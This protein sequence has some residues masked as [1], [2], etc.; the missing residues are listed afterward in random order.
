ME[1]V[2]IYGIGNP[3]VDVSVSVSDADIEALGLSKG[4][5][6]LIETEQR[7]R[8]LEHIRGKDVSYGCGGSAPNSMIT[9]AALG[10]ATALGG[11]IADDELGDIYKQRLEQ[12]GV[13]N[14]L[15]VYP[16]E[17]GT[18]IILVTPDGERTMC[19]FL[20]TCM[21][22]RDTDVDEEA[23]RAA[24]WLHF[25]G[26]MFD[27]EGQ[28]A[29]I[30]HAAQTTHSAGGKISFDVADPFAVDR[31]YDAF[32]ELIPRQVDLLFANQLEAEKLTGKSDPLEAAQHFAEHVETAVVKDGKNGSVVVSGGHVTRIKPYPAEL[33][34]SNGAGDT[35]AAAFLSVL[36]EDGSHAQA[37]QFA[38]FLSAKVVERSGAQ[39]DP[40]DALSFRNEHYAMASR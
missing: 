13:A 31:H 12:T 38:S 18:S 39:L 32:I 4:I 37:G 9:A 33:V 7:R 6:H 8:I 27:T 24:K 28:R 35:Y 15:A 17:T 11:G 22:F 26:Y 40:E 19:T 30:E 36:A 34:D 25:T 16:G 20:G 1:K 2:D 5:M 10:K 23:A 14:R 29:A 21:L 3:L